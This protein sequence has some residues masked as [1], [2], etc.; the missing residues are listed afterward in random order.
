MEINVKIKILIYGRESAMNR[1]LSILLGTV[2]M[3]IILCVIS[4]FIIPDVDNIILSRTVSGV[5]GV[6]SWAIALFIVNK[7][8]KNPTATNSH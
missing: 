7:V 1:T 2:I 3:Y 6:I 5:F 4:Y 8:R